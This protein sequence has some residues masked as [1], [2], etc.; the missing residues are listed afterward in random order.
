MLASQVKTIIAATAHMHNFQVVTAQAIL[1]VLADDFDKT[2]DALIQ[3]HRNLH[4]FKKMLTVSTLEALKN[5]T[6]PATFPSGEKFCFMAK[7]L[8]IMFSEGE[9][10]L[11]EIA[12]KLTDKYI[13]SL[14]DATSQLEELFDSGFASYCLQEKGSRDN[15]KI[16]EKDRLNT[17]Q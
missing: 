17:R 11:E 2:Q 3:L 13:H 15:A 16:K 9:R 1:A 14:H 8:T 12:A 5:P 10:Y 4:T 7:Q 6:M